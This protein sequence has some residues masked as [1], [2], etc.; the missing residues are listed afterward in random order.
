MSGQLFDVSAGWFRAG[1]SGR[2]GSALRLAVRR[3][4]GLALTTLVLWP[5]PAMARVEPPI[6]QGVPG[7]ASQ[8][9]LWLWILL[10]LVVVGV[11]G[12]VAWARSMRGLAVRP[13]VYA[14]VRRAIEAGPAA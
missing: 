14:M 5:G 9:A 3:L 13:D 6:T 8:V 7:E 11:V 1:W 10:A 2:L 12:A 4:G